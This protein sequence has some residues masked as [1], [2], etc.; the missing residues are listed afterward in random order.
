MAS[1]RRGSAD[2]DGCMVFVLI[3]LFSVLFGVGGYGSG[4]DAGVRAAAKGEAVVVQLPNGEDM[5]VQVKKEPKH[6]D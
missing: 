5:V 1:K 4:Y 2:G 6:G 3:L